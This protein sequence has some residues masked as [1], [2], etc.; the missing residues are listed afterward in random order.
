MT[1]VLVP[2]QPFNAREIDPDFDLERSAARS[3]GFTSCAMARK[4]EPATDGRG[5]AIRA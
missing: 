4:Y 2:S 3:T 5:Y 1:L